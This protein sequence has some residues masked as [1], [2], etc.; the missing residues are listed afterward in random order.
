MWYN[1][2]VLMVI[3][4][5]YDLIICGWVFNLDIFLVCYVFLI[6]VRGVCDELKGSLICLFGEDVMD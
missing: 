4:V 5:S 3:F 2:E 1:K 6:N